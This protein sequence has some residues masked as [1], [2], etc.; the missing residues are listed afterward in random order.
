MTL[1]RQKSTGGKG[2]LGKPARLLWLSLLGFVLVIAAGQGCKTEADMSTTG[3]LQI[4]QFGGLAKVG[5]GKYLYVPE[6]RGFDIIVPGQ[7]DSGDVSVLVGREVRGEGEFNADWPSIL[8]AKRI[9]VKEGE[10]AWKTVFT[11][12]AEPALDDYLHLHEREK[13][14]A[15]RNLSF[16]KKEDWEGKERVK[17][18]G[19]LETETVMEGGAEK[20]ISRIV[21]LNEENQAVGK[22]IVDSISDV[23]RYYI[24]K[25]RLFDN[26]WIYITVKE[27]VDWN[28]RK[29]TWDLFHADVLF[30]GLF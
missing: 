30:A 18:Y 6:A 24:Q 12:T 3:G 28:T 5:I 27:T 15:L 23:A 21:V 29:K 1:I 10:R 9:D 25:L 26:L 2:I 4:I 22:I 7:V 14:Q 11:R 16:E 8:V 13:V 20:D 17:V 19:R